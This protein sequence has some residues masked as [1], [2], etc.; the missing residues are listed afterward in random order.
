MIQDDDIAQ[1]LK[2]YDEAFDFYMD[3]GRLPDTIPE[4]DILGDFI[5]RTIDDNPQLSSQ[6]H[7]WRELLKDEIMQFIENMLE[8]FQPI[9]EKYRKEKAYIKLFL[10][11]D[12]EYKKQMWSKVVYTIKLYYKPQEINVD[13][14][15]RQLDVEDQETVFNAFLKDWDK[16]SDERQYRL[17]HQA[18]EHN[19]KEWEQQVKNHGLTDYRNRQQVEQIFYSYPKLKEILKIIGREE[20]VREEE[21]DDTVLRYLPLLPSAPRPAAE[22]EEIASGKDLQHLLPS[23]MAIMSDSQAED[24]FYLKYATGQLQ[25]FANRP[26]D[27]SQSKTEQKDQKKPRLGNGPII[28]AVDTSGSMSGRAIEIA[29]SLLLQLLDLAKKQKRKCFLISFAVRAQ[30]LDLALPSNRIRLNDFL[31]NKFTGGTNGEQMLNTAIKMLQT[32]NYQMA[33]VL[34]ISD[35]YF[36]TPI[37]ETRDKIKIEQ[38]KGTKFYGL[39][40]GLNNM[41]SSYD[42]I[43]DQNWVV[44]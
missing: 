34:I 16:A 27:E 18:L 30:Y 23:E 41:G 22:V 1:N 5:V 28:V 20:H 24:L 13:G 37:K 42:K 33:D 14:Y 11:G 31:T 10:S 29:Y 2:I 9:E 19:Q 32:D 17:L 25:L 35:F 43:L 6:D 7:L 15:I 38:R 21:M 26:K 4:G 36:P 8:I 3:V 40:I 12:L 44:N 39:R